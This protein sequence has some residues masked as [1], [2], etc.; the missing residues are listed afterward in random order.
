MTK[1]QILIQKIVIQRKFYDDE[2]L[3]KRLSA[4]ILD[5]TIHYCSQNS[6]PITPTK[7]QP[8]LQTSKSSIRKLRRTWFSKMV[9]EKLLITVSKIKKESNEEREISRGRIERKGK[10]EENL[11]YRAM[12]ARIGWP[13]KRK[14]FEITNRV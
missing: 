14:P 7:K 4:A 10:G 11:I 2:E 3:A 9:R 8:N 5:S 6:H 12:E 1:I 13:P